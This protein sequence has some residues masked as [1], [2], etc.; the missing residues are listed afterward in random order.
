MLLTIEQLHDDIRMKAALPGDEALSLHPDAF[1]SNDLLKLERERIFRKDWICVGR[2]DEVPGAGDYFTTTV[3]SVPVIIVRNDDGELRAL[4]NV[5]RHRMATVAKGLGKTRVFVCPYHAWSYDLNGSLVSA[6]N[7][8]RNDFNKVNCQLPSVPLEI[9]QGFIF[10][11]LDEN[12][13]SLNAE[14]DRFTQLIK[15]YHVEN[16]QSVWK[17]S[18][19]WKTNWKVLVENFLDAYHI[20]IVHRDTILPY[21]GYD[22]MKP[23]EPGKIYSFY[24]QGQV[25]DENMYKEI[26]PTRILMENPDLGEFEKCNTFVGCIYPSF[27]ISISW[28]G[29]L[30]LS[31][32]P[33]SA[34]EIY[35]DWGVAGPVKGLPRNADNYEEYFFPAWINEVNNEDKARVESIQIAAQSGFAVTGPLHAT[36]EKT[37]QEFIRYLSRRLNHV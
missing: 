32:H 35:I 33:I 17:K 34:G 1:V 14:L 37:V 21:G 19:T 28:F 23:V 31:L 15:H 36:H 16:M 2:D 5:C 22:L 24:V 20:D 30:W 6:P 9:W 25:A 11:N 4:V 26:I 3:D 18:L 12:A 13:Y 8:V 7:M 29:V 10:V 27:L